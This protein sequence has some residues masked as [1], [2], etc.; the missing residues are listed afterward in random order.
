MW[1]IKELENESVTID[2][3]KK[4]KFIKKNNINSFSYW[5]FKI[6][7]HESKFLEILN[8]LFYLFILARSHFQI[9]QL[10]N[11]I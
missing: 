3:L 5:L 9:M 4:N 1:V 6:I 7:S 2:M 10:R 11:I 8:Y